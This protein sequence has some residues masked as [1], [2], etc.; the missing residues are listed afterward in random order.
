M[1]R[2]N[3][4]LENSGLQVRVFRSAGAVE[5]LAVAG[6]RHE[7]VHHAVERHVVV[8]AVARELLDALGMLGREIGAQLDDD[9]ALG[10]VDHDRILLVETGGKR[11]RDRGSGADQRGDEGESSDHEN[12]GSGRVESRC[13]V[14]DVLKRARIWS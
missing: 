13:A 9:A 10:G 7:A 14:I 6:L 8:I 1:P 3:G 4:T 12:S 2:L 11:L 5:I